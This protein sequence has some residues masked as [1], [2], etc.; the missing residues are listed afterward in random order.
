MSSEFALY[1]M[2]FASI[3]ADASR[4]DGQCGA[5]HPRMPCPHTCQTP[6]TTIVSPRPDVSAG[7]RL[8]PGSRHTPK[9]LEKASARLSPPPQQR[10]ACKMRVLIG[11]FVIAHQGSSTSSL[12]RVSY[13]SGSLSPKFGINDLT[14][15]VSNHAKWSDRRRHNLA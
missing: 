4:V 2:L 12:C 11:A 8:W 3:S 1:R 15:F 14:N 5:A 7:I 9:D 13:S 10:M 6:K